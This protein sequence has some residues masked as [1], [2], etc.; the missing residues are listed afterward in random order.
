MSWIE[1]LLVLAAGLSP[2]WIIGHSVSFQ[3]RTD[4]LHAE[5]AVKHYWRERALNCE[6]AEVGDCAHP[7][8]QQEQED[9]RDAE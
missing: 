8:A 6:G 9:G 1:A 7:I 3:R 5:Q 2:G 4:S